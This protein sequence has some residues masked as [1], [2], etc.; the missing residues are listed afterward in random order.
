MIHNKEKLNNL[1][2]IGPYLGLGTQLAVTVVS[3]FFL[4]YWLDEKFNTLPLFVLVLS[5]IGT[6]GGLYNFIRSVMHLN[7][8]KKENND[9]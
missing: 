4:G 8:R 3:L 9:S 7:E 1:R 5:M 6:F 2:E